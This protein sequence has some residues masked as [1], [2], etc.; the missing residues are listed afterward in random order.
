MMLHNYGP[1]YNCNNGEWENL[2]P[3]LQKEGFSVLKFDLR[4]HGVNKGNTKAVNSPKDFCMY[5]FNGR[6]CA[7]SLHPDSPPKNLSL[8]VAK[9]T[10]GY[11]PFLIND[12][13]GGRDFL[14]KRNDQGQCNS[15]RINVICDREICPLAM[16]WLGIEF[17]RNGK[18][19]ANVNDFA[20][21]SHNAGT[22][23]MSMVC[24][25][26]KEHPG[27]SLPYAALSRIKEKD[28]PEGI[29]NKVSVLFID[30]PKTAVQSAN[31]WFTRWGLQG[32]D[33]AAVLTVAVARARD[34]LVTPRRE[35]ASVH[36]AAE[37]EAVVPRAVGMRERAELHEQRAALRLLAVLP[38]TRGLHAVRALAHA[39]L[40]LDDREGGGG[41]FAV[42]VG[43][44]GPG[45][46]TG[47]REA[48]RV[49]RHRGE[50]WRRRGRRRGY[51]DRGARL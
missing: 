34:E 12:I 29:K 50:L 36:A 27:F 39:L 7:G 20:A 11:Y 25:S 14:D 24:F 46:A 18:Y 22:D 16:Y 31:Y 33:R 6:A 9:F 45:A 10:A 32:N 42:G 40:G 48:R 28:I 13:A 26:Y 15:G 8:D 1:K 3:A 2:A 44:H 49:Q 19:R 38:V 43:D 23:I 21:P 4:G 30:N 51:R 5:K 37:A 17:A 47:P 41:G 35:L